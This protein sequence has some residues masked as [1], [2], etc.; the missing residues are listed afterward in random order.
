MPIPHSWLLQTCTKTFSKTLIRNFISCAVYLDFRKAFVSMNHSICW[1]AWAL[2]SKRKSCKQ[3]QLYLSNRKQ[4]VQAMAWPEVWTRGKSICKGY[5]IR[6]R[7]PISKHLEKTWEI[8]VNA[9]VDGYTKT[10]TTQNTTKNAKK[11]HPAENQENTKPNVY[12]LS[13]CQVFKFCLPAGDSSTCPSVSYAA[14][15]RGNTLNYP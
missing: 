14:A 13:G 3:I 2:R 6:C 10:Q 4:Y 8:M 15:F 1:K 11:Q 12:K 7:G 9:D 5:T